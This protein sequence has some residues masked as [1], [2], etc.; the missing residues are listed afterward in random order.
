MLKQV[1]SSVVVMMATTVAMAKNS[2]STVVSPYYW[3]AQV[4]YAMHYGFDNP[5]EYNANGFKYA[6][7]ATF[8]GDFAARLS[9]GYQFNDYFG[10]EI[11]QGTYG[12]QLVAYGVAET[13]ARVTGK[14]PAAKVYPKNGYDF[15]LTGRLSV[16]DDMSVIAKLGL[17]RIDIEADV[18]F[19]VPDGFF[20]GL[21]YDMWHTIVRAELGIQYQ[22]SQATALTVTYAHYYGISSN[23]SM[24]TGDST[25]FEKIFTTMDPN[26][27]MASIGIVHHF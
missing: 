3:A 21:H 14:I 20:S 16:A 23:A 12:E 15:N 11:G 6:T 22:L 27:G 26:F 7:Y 8:Q 10:V 5:G 17:A 2:A 1:L 24:L 4:G 13:G 9:V 25:S 18:Y 19:G